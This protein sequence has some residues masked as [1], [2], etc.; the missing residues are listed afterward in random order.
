MGDDTNITQYTRVSQDESAPA[1]S[2]P[3]IQLPKTS[4]T[5]VNSYL[6]YPGKSL[7]SPIFALAM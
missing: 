7:P 3:K 2:I 5:G 6:C 4:F 1:A